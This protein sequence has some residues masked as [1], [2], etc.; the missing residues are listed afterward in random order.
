MILSNGQFP[1]LLSFL[2][3]IF[4]SIKSREIFYKKIPEH[5]YQSIEKEKLLI[6]CLAVNRLGRTMDTH[7]FHRNRLISSNENNLKN[8]KMINKE[9]TMLQLIVTPETT[10]LYECRFG[11]INFRNQSKFFNINIIHFATYNDNND[12]RRKIEV[13]CDAENYHIADEKVFASSKNSYEFDYNPDYES[14]LYANPPAT[15]DCYDFLSNIT[16]KPPQLISLSFDMELSKENMTINCQTQHF[17]VCLGNSTVKNSYLK[18]GDKSKVEVVDSWKEFNRLHLFKKKAFLIRENNYT[19]KIPLVTQYFTKHDLKLSCIYENSYGKSNELAI[20]FVVPYNCDTVICQ[21]STCRYENNSFVC[22]SIPEYDVEVGGMLTVPIY[23]YST[24]LVHSRWEMFDEKKKNWEKIK[25]TKDLKSEMN[26]RSSLKAVYLNVTKE[27]EGIYR[28]IVRTDHFT[29]DHRQC[30]LQWKINV[31]EPVIASYK[32][33]KYKIIL[34]VAIVILFPLLIFVF[35]YSQTNCLERYNCFG[36]SSKKHK[37]VNSSSTMERFFTNKYL[38]KSNLDMMDRNDLKSNESLIIP[39]DEE[40]EKNLNNY[41]FSFDLNGID[42]TNSLTSL[43]KKNTAYLHSTIDAVKSGNHRSEC[44][45][46]KESTTY[47]NGMLQNIIEANFQKQLNELKKRYLKNYEKMKLENEENNSHKNSKESIKQLI[48]T[49]FDIL[50]KY[51]KMIQFAA[52]WEYPRERIHLGKV[53]GNGAFG[54]VRKAN[55]KFKDEEKSKFHVAVKMLNDEDGKDHYTSIRTT[56][57]QLKSGEVNSEELKGLIQ[58]MQLLAYVGKH[59]NIVS[60]FGV[61]TFIQNIEQPLFILVEYCRHGDLKKYLQR[62]KPM[63]SV[64]YTRQSSLTRNNDMKLY[65]EYGNQLFLYF[66]S[67]STDFSDYVESQSNELD[68]HMF[69]D[70]LVDDLSSNASNK[71]NSQSIS[72][73]KDKIFSEKQFRKKFNSYA[74]YNE[75][76]NSVIKSSNSQSTSLTDSGNGDD[77]D[78]TF[79]STSTNPFDI[80]ENAVDDD[81]LN[82][83]QLFNFIHQIAKGMEYLASKKI[84][85][86]DLAARNILVYSHNHVKIADFGLAKNSAYYMGSNDGQMPLKWMAIE[87]ILYAKYSTKSDV[88]SFGVLMWEILSYGGNPYENLTTPSDIVRFIRQ[89]HRLTVPDNIVDEFQQKLCDILMRSCWNKIAEHRPS[90]AE[91]NKNIKQIAGQLLLNTEMYQYENEDLSHTHHRRQS[92]NNQHRHHHYRSS[93]QNKKSEKKQRKRL[94]SSNEH[95]IMKGKKNRRTKDNIDFKSV[96]M[97]KLS[98]SSSLELNDMISEENSQMYVNVPEA[99]E[100]DND[101]RCERHRQ[102]VD[103]EINISKKKVE[104]HPLFFCQI[105]KP[106]RVN[107]ND[108]SSHPE[109]IYST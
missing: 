35:I 94:S 72:F 15:D 19:Y 102:L 54:I 38:V 81:T 101:E 12:E 85:H 68:K 84:I 26:R 37:S 51:P 65:N 62:H 83:F 61:C 106:N 100:Q 71:N 82:I 13:C 59:E 60:L 97:R 96:R 79:T 52:M 20:S 88:W 33:L 32:F 41:S 6:E 76:Q 3:F 17:L 36:E 58:E 75:G 70:H 93:K 25:D 55:I 5:E 99:I 50:N 77:V 29:N 108:L 90:F 39:T 11:D 22:D 4:T 107:L 67:I 56:S 14:D 48:D 105:K 63:R 45:N 24:C 73:R 27:H 74:T 21:G 49:K 98:S 16:K 40:I 9:H 2:I 34:I 86:R 44:P 30:M 103:E 109:F 10:G 95:G 78:T 28:Y 69:F 31:I 47:Q 89:G 87:S 66:K 91:L 43:M 53:L 57:E 8:F 104:P 18:V 23:H 92:H 80:L 46:E 64:F 7:W 42:H 1:I